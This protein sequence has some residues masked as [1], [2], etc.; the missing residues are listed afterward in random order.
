[1]IVISANR[2]YDSLFSGRCQ[3]ADFSN[4]RA[5]AERI[6]GAT[7]SLRDPKDLLIV[8]QYLSEL[9]DRARCKGAGEGEQ[10]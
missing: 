3:M 6:R 4:P 7:D 2:N 8:K 5:A 9:E 10:T 1:M